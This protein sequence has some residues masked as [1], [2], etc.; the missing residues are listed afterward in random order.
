MNKDQPSRTN[1]MDLSDCQFADSLPRYYNSYRVQGRQPPQLFEI[2]VSNCRPCNF[3]YTIVNSILPLILPQGEPESECPSRDVLASYPF[4]VPEKK[5]D[6][7]EVK[8]HIFQCKSCFDTVRSHQAPTK[9]EQRSL[10]RL[11]RNAEAQRSA[12]K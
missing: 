1:D 8:Q 7:G 5:E 11:L 12:I 4:N 3:R 2:H 6:Y 10:E 9:Q